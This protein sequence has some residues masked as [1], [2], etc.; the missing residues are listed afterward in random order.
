MFEDNLRRLELHRPFGPRPAV[1][2][3]LHGVREL[4]LGD[5]PLI[6]E[7]P[8]LPDLI[9]AAIALASG[10]R[11]KLILPLS[12]AAA[13]FAL[14][15]RG[16]RVLVDCYGTESAPEIFLREREIALGELLEVCIEASR[17]TAQQHEGTALGGAL[18]ELGKRL[19][20]TEVRPDPQPQPAR[21]SCSGGS[22]HSPGR[23]VPL[24]FGFNA[25][26][27]PSLDPAPESH[28]FADVHALLFQG[29]LWAFAGERR[30][31]VFEGPIMLAAQRM[32]AAV[33]ALI[34]AWQADRPVHVRLRSAGFWAAVRCERRGKVALTLGG[35][36][37]DAPTWPALEVRDAALPIL[38][39]TSDLIR[40]LIAADRRQTQNLRVAALRAEVRALRRII[41]ARERLESFENADPER[42]RLSQP[43][44][45]RAAHTA[46]R[47]A[48]VPAPAALRY[49]Q[50]WSAEID[51]LDASSVYLCGEQLLLASAK[52]TVALARGTGQVQ[53][54]M[55][56]AG[57]VTM[58]AGR[59]LLRLSPDGELSLHEVDD[60]TAYA[61]AQITPRSGGEG[62]ALF[63][64]GGTLPP[65]AILSETRQHLVAIDLRTGQPRW[66]FRAHG[67]NG[68]QL[69]RS[70]RV[71]LVTSG[72][73]TLDAL[74][75]ASGE[76]VWRFSDTVRFC[77]RP[78]VCSETAI[79]VAGSPS[80]GAGAVYGLELYSG[81]LL[82]QR[83]LP[84][85]PSS[86]PVHAGQVVIAPYGRSQ[87]ARLL[88]IDPRSGATRWTQPDPG[89]DNGAQALSLD[90]TLVVNAP[91]GR[92]VALEL[93]T[94]ETRWTRALSNPLTDDVPRQLEPSL[95]QGA[96]FV[97]SAQ[98][99]VLRPQD[100]SPLC[101][102][103]CDLVPDWLRV[104]ERGWFYVAEE[105]G[106]LSAYAAAPHL[107]L[108]R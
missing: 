51:G 44:P 95:R 72:D 99:H 50:R 93:A 21:V 96:L 100:G 105:S 107:S 75:L 61:R 17:K 22:L 70:G 31:Q 52:L 83:E 38:R 73:G 33:R 65:M 16:D 12:G 11:R 54:S 89:L 53:W 32:V 76:V 1:P 101:Q 37:N 60:G 28:A 19:A 26:I 78:A 57:A 104:D 2:D 18:R 40:K 14:V 79:A 92:A 86:E 3:A 58:L 66:R 8:A 47:L 62:P 42:L 68:L 84:A 71:L 45:E 46:L 88:A 36:R 6:L 98:V 10:T 39:L 35:G 67:D 4:L 91:S 30:V 97:P 15:R 64:A 34:D 85:A 41:R 55:P 29:S 59:C 48:P 108:V 49:S 25:E 9:A 27:F 74:D 7:L 81:R 43:Q 94:G 69:A 90:H 13:E 5:R 23:N 102:V 80:G 24:A 106:H 77:L 56:T 63:A 82:W 103:G 20:D 87:K